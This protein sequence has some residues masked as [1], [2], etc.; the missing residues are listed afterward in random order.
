[1]NL[2]YGDPM[3]W[4]EVPAALTVAIVAELTGHGLA[5][6][7]ATEHSVV[8]PLDGQAPGLS[9]P[10]DRGEHLYALWGSARPEWSWGT[11][12]PNAPAGGLLWPLLS[13]PDDPVRITA[14]I[15][16]VLRTGRALP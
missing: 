7:H 5:G 4:D 12:H 14:Q 8:V 10:A 11:A 2:P 3:L 13:P 9:G 6:V 15:R 16:Q 1:M